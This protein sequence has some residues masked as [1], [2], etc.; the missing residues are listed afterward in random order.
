MSRRPIVASVHHL[1]SAREPAARR[2]TVLTLGASLMAMALSGAALPVLA[3]DAFPSQPLKLVVPFGPGS[4]PDQV[5]RIVGEK[6]GALLGQTIVVENKPGASGNIGTNAIATAK[7]DG[8]TFGVSITGPLVNNTLLF[9]KLPYDPVKDLSP[10]T[11]AVHQPNVLVV[12]SDSGIANIAQLLEML[13]KQ[14]GKS[15]FPSTGAG[16]VSH[17]SV[18]LMLQQI[19]SSATHVPYPS[20]PA[21][22][23]SLV[24]GDTQFGALPPVAVMPM[25][26]EGRLKAL[27]V[28]SSRRSALLPDIPTLAEVGVPGIE[29]SA[30]IGFVVGSKVPAAIQKTLSDAL[31]AALQDPTVRSRLQAVYMDPVGESPAAFRSYMDDELKR[32]GPLIKKLNLKSE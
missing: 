27:A 23:T 10:L 13:K 22:L 21:A 2:R 11:L 1:A 18:E 31:I 3:A 24:A 26:K 32:W 28:T 20:S 4:S 15:N 12:R 9:D 25:V 5:A 29:G 6:A 14:P 8:Y 7:P 19:G 16:T 30:W 17:L